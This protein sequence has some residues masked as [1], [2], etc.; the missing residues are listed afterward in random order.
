MHELFLAD[1]DIVLSG[2][3]GRVIKTIDVPFPRPRR[4]DVMRSEAFHRLADV[5]AEALEPPG[6]EL[7]A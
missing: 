6:D 1:R 4:P 3:P 2:R 5:L 7:R